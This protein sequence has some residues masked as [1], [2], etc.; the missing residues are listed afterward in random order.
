M[1]L[2]KYHVTEQ[3]YDSINSSVLRAIRRSD[4]RPVILKCPKTSV[5]TVERRARF[6]RNTSW[7]VR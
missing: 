2:S 3:L 7:L 6:K 4:G 5:V 1:P